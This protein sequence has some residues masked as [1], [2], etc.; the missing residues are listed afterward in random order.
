MTSS[1]TAQ[2][3]PAR[4]IGVLYGVDLRLAGFRTPKQ[5]HL[6]SELQA[7]FKLLKFEIKSKVHFFVFRSCSGLALLQQCFENTKPR[8]IP[9]SLYL[10]TVLAKLL[11]EM[12]VGQQHLSAGVSHHELQ[13]LTR[14]CRV[15]GNI[16]PSRFQHGQLGHILQRPLLVQSRSISG[17]R[18]RAS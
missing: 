10:G 17:V 9:K 1:C 11:I 13:P 4:Q 15:Q 14:V 3:Q 12:L 7:C 16:S 18:P 6:S 5:H 2:A 8:Q